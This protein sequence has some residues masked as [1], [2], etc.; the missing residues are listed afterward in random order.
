MPDGMRLFTISMFLCVYWSPKPKKL[1]VGDYCTGALGRV[2]KPG[3]YGLGEEIAR[4]VFQSLKITSTVGAW[5]PRPEAL[6]HRKRPPVIEN[7]I[8]RRGV[9]STPRGIEIQNLHEY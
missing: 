6:S 5:F 3:P 1:K 7:R 9:V 4:D 8:N 2:R